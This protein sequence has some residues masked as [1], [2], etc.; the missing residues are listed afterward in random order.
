MTPMAAIKARSKAKIKVAIN[1]N[2]PHVPEKTIKAQIRQRTVKS[3]QTLRRKTS[4]K[5][6]KRK[7]DSWKSIFEKKKK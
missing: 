7:L 6:L 5:G 4:Q 1:E 2:I 3:K